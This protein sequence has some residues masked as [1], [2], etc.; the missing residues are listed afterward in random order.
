MWDREVVN[1]ITGTID[2]FHFQ[3]V[4]EVRF[5]QEGCRV[6]LPGRVGGNLGQDFLREKGCALSAQHAHRLAESRRLMGGQ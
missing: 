2:V 5:G 1:G 3:G 4:L 6:L